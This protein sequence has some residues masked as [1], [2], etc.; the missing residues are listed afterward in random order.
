[1]P[2][3]MYTFLG[4]FF[5]MCMTWHF[6]VLNCIP[7]LSAQA[8]S[9]SSVA[10]RATESSGDSMNWAILV[11]SANFYDYLLLSGFHVQVVYDKQ[12][13]NWDSG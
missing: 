12:E 11:S 5:P 9:L 3:I 10:W 2:F 4:L 6:A 1:M 7:Y 13:Q 8:P